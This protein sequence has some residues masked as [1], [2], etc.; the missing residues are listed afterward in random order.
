M[1]NKTKY[2][3]LKIVLTAF[4]MTGLAI[5]SPGCFPVF[6]ELQSARMLGPNN[7]EITPAFS[8]VFIYGDGEMEHMLDHFGIQLGM[9]ISENV[10]FRLRYDFVN[11]ELTDWLWDE[12]V[13]THIFSLGPKIRLK[14]GRSAFFIPLA[15]AVGE[16]V[17]IIDTMTINPT[18]LWTYP[19]NENI[20]INPSVK[21][22]I[23]VA[24]VSG[25]RLALN[26]GASIST[27]LVKWALRPEIGYLIYAHGGCVHFSLGFSYFSLRSSK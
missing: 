22:L 24:F 2:F 3:F 23:P 8:S 1:T 4:V 14:K 17:P 19:I 6:S 20:E 12:T 13:V 16:G 21:L 9:G 15:F 10:D 27:D 11:M 25:I 26:L 5:V 7:H 18:V